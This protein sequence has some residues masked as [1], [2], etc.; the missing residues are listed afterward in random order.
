[1]SNTYGEDDRML[2]KL[3]RALMAYYGPMNMIQTVVLEVDATIEDM[4]I[5][6]YVQ[7][8]KKLATILGDV[9]RAICVSHTDEASSDT[10]H[11]TTP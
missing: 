8:A 4:A 1:V 3:V 2:H 11:Q 9:R 5:N 10:V 7:E 6:G